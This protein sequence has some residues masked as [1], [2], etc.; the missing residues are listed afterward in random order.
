MQESSANERNELRSWRLWYRKYRLHSVFIHFPIALI[1]L[2]FLSHIFF[3]FTGRVFFFNTAFF[4]QILSLLAILAALGTGFIGW[5]I[6]YNQS[7]DIRFRVKILCTIIILASTFTAILIS[8]P[9]AIL[10]EL[11]PIQKENPKFLITVG[12]TFI[13]CILVGIISQNGKKTTWV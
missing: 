1:P 7:L 8:A 4:V 3:L 12:L 10:Q 9:L 11:T 5:M 6:N 2:A 13:N